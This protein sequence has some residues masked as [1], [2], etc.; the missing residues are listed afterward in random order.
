M[1]QQPVCPATTHQGSSPGTSP[2]TYNLH[3]LKEPLKQ[4]TM[5]NKILA[6]TPST[7]RLVRRNAETFR[8]SVQIN[9]GLNQEGAHF[10][11]NSL[12][13]LPCSRVVGESWD[14]ES[15]DGHRGPALNHRHLQP[16]GVNSVADSNPFQCLKSLQL[17]LSFP[18]L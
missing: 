16:A 17:M 11:V 3:L 13:T 4:M 5:I 14:W 7:P 9:L 18:K 10:D 8:S 2:G 6:V 15:R 12:P 1:E